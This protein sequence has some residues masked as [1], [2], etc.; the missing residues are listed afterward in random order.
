MSPE[1]IEK[2]EAFARAATPGPWGRYSDPIAR[3]L[4]VRGH[5]VGEVVLE[6][7]HKQ[8]W[9]ATDANA[10]YLA[11]HSP[12]RLLALYAEVRRA[13]AAF[14]WIA[15]KVTFAHGKALGGDLHGAD[16]VKRALSEVSR[17]E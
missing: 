6:V 16:L 2:G 3:R 12:D 7:R 11:F 9:D 4:W 15:S 1:E 5:G 17:D 10:D 13:E 8:M 14:R